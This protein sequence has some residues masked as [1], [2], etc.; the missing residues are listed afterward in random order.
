MKD[1]PDFG[2]PNLLNSFIKNTTVDER[3]NSEF[4]IKF[5]EDDNIEDIKS[6]LDL[7]WNLNIKP[8][9]WERLG[10]RSSLHEVQTYLYK[11]KNPNCTWIQVIADDFIYT[12]PGFVTEIL[13]IPDNY[14]YIGTEAFVSPKT[15]GTAPCFSRKLMDACCGDFGPQ[16]NSDGFATGLNEIMNQKYNI[17]LGLDIEPYYYRVS[18]NTSENW[19]S[20]FNK[21]TKDGLDIIYSLMSKNI[22][23]NILN[24][25]NYD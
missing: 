4:L 3:Q 19:D 15:Q 23:L 12:R 22:Y 24:D 18:C 25:K 14:N 1:N 20:S 16:P 5:D 2:L 7:Y 17:N 6:I 10:G 8:F 21:M 13:N 11:Y 9:F